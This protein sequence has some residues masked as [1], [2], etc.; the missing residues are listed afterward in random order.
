MPFRTCVFCGDMGG[1]LNSTLVQQMS[2][3]AGRRGLDTQGH[4]VY[5]GAKAEFVEKMVISKIPALEG[6]DPR[7]LTMFIQNICSEFTN[8]RGFDNQMSIMGQCPLTEHINPRRIF[9]MKG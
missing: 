8:P 3:R 6:Q 1:R 7:Y 2:G 5:A 9:N 4:L